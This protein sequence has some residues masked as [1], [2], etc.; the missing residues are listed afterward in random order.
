[1]NEKRRVFFICEMIF[2]TLIT[3]SSII[4]FV[5]KAVVLAASS[6]YT[7]FQVQFISFVPQTSNA[8]QPFRYSEAI[9]FNMRVG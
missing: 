6:G 9:R 3:L 2:I 8:R 4:S 7:A 5:S 1:M